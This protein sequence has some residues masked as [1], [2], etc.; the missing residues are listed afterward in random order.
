MNAD[1]GGFERFVQALRP[2]LDRVVIVG[3]WAHRLYRWHPLAQP[4]DYPPLMTRDLDVAITP[5]ALPRG[6]SVHE[7]LTE[8]GF[9]EELSGEHDPPVSH[10]RLEPERGVFVVEFVTPL[11]GS[12]RKRSG[13]PDATE[14]IA[15]VSAQKL[16]YLELLAIAPWQVSLDPGRGLQLSSPATVRVPNPATYI[17]QKLLIRSKR[18]PAGKRAKDLLYIH[19][20]IEL[21]GDSLGDLNETWNHRVKPALE[22]KALRRLR[23]SV[24]EL[25]ARAS[26]DLAAAVVEGRAASGRALS[27]ESVR[28]VCR[29]GLDELLAESR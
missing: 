12:S 22:K 16:R 20:T 15:G 29:A 10:Y 7:R 1:V 4:L 17:A 2:W 24:D 21:F 28:E 23:E 9:A 8:A 14:I 19:D 13:A 3:G 18:K 27:V 25:L 6:A 11:T 26:D 5:N